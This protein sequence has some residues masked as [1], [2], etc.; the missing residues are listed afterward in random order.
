MSIKSKAIGQFNN[1]VAAG[2][3]PNSFTGR[4]LDAVGGFLSGWGG[5]AKQH[6]GVAYGVGVGDTGT[7]LSGKYQGSYDMGMTGANRMPMSI[8][9]EQMTGS[10]LDEG[11]KA[12][13]NDNLQNFAA[14]GQFPTGKSSLTPPPQ[15]PAMGPRTARAAQWAIGKVEANP[16]MNRWLN[17]DQ[18]PLQGPEDPF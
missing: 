8:G 16:R 15:A 4:N 3:D 12:E 13:I 6:T 5:P 18:A 10:S 11:T 2:A 17:G 14:T 1:M 7:G 9:G